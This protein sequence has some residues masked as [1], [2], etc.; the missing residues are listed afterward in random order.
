MYSS[1]FEVLKIKII[2]LIDF[3][4]PQPKE[5]LSQKNS[6][7][8]AA[9]EVT[10]EGTG[11][12]FWDFIVQSVMLNSSSR[13]LRNDGT[14]KIETDEF[15]TSPLEI[16]PNNVFSNSSLKSMEAKRTTMSELT[17]QKN[18]S[19]PLSYS[20]PAEREPQLLLS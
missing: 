19:S 14:D 3:A 1:V 20:P 7:L 16:L 9:N 13:I 15:V 4:I 17:S 11:K 10:V 12:S 8:P 2:F 5:M 18:K 6:M